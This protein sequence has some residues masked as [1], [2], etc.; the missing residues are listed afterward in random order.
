MLI[1]EKYK[2]IFIHIQ[3]TGG[4]SLMEVLSETIPDL[5]PLC[6]KHDGATEGIA[7]LG[8]DEWKK[9]FKFAFVRNPWDRMVSWYSMIINTPEKV[10]KLRLYARNNSTN[11]EE[12]LRNCT[13]SIS[14]DDGIQSFSKNQLDYLIDGNGKLAVDYIGRF[15]SLDKSFKYFLK[16]VNFD[17]KIKLPHVNHGSLHKHYSTYYNESTREIV[18]ERFLKDIEKFSYSFDKKSSINNFIDSI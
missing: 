16:K 12:F 14:D 18:A 5:R 17:D 8:E 2:F 4:T 9:Y 10:T 11:F 7:E 6:F 3:K 15:E 1:S 13:D